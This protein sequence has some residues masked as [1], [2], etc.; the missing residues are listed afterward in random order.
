MKRNRKIYE[1]NFQTV[2]RNV[3]TVTHKKLKTLQILTKRQKD[4]QNA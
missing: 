3:Y 1:E 4:N 2:I